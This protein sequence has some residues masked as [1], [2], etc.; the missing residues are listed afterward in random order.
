MT[1]SFTALLGLPTA[2]LFAAACSSNGS[3]SDGDLSSCG[4]IH[5]EASAE[6]TVEVQGGCVARC[7]PVNF[8]A[9]CRGECGGNFSASCH[10]NCSAECQGQCEVNP[11]N[12]SCEGSCQAQCSGSCAGQCEADADSASCVA[13]CEATCE[14]ECG[15]SCEG[16]PPSASCE[17]KCEAS[18]EGS[19]VVE[20]NL[21]CNLECQAELQGGCEV[22][23]Q[24]PE[25][26]LFC[27][28]Q[29]VDHG[30]NLEKCIAALNAYLEVEV[31]ASSSAACEGNSCSAEAQASVRCS[32]AEVGAPA[33]APSYWA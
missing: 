30:G 6:C 21:Q 8:T 10:G 9:A 1:K 7:Q 22:E 25:G 32:V 31:D 14:G 12:F 29:Y 23:C 33:G 11:G 3:S 2:L 17:A 24:S 16:T 4:N 28:G 20:A 27:D 18:C 15:A 19:C 13:R 5:I 26:A